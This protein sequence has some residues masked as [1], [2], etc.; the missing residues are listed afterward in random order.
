MSKDKKKPTQQGETRHRR[1]DEAK[2][3]GYHPGPP[4]T[5]YPG[6]EL[7]RAYVLIQRFGQVYT[8]AQ[9]LE[10][11]TLFPELYCPYPY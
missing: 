8:P 3:T 6:M 7:A 5:Y 11:G 10:T 4:G 9:A 2:A 1:E